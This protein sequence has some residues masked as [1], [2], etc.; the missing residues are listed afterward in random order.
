VIAV[1]RPIRELPP[2]AE[3][4]LSGSASLAG[5]EAGDIDR[6]VLVENV[7][8]AAEPLRSL[9]QRPDL[10]DEYRALKAT[11]DDYELRKREFFERVVAQL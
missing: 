1:E 4:H 5:L 11:P 6:L 3:V 7:A 10:L 8:A 2:A 9:P